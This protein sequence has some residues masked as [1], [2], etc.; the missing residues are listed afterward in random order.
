MLKY[1]QLGNTGMKLSVL[2]MG[3]SGFGNVYGKYNEEEATR[4]VKY[5]VEKGVN[6]FDTAYWYGQGKSETFLGKALKGIPRSSFYIGTKVG[7]YERDTPNMFDFTSSKVTRSAEESLE[8]LQLS[9]VDLLQVHDV[10]FTPSVDVIVNEALP[11]L[12]KLRE[13]GVCRF[14]GI[15]GYELPV[16]KKVIERSQVKIDSVLSY[17][18][19]T[20]NDTTLTEYFDQFKKMGVPIINASPVSMGLL[21]QYKIQDWHPATD[22]IRKACSD[23]VEYCESQGVDITRIAV[24]YS[25]GFEQVC[26]DGAMNR[27]SWYN[28]DS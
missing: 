25:A 4:V 24:N 5:A 2:G 3:G 11:A 28:R 1:R 21:T 9:Y 8:R 16:L 10:E 19:L 27:W 7:R 13:S 22:D 14:I 20:L 18:R 23:A 6:Y 17:C 15:T 26:V 12:D